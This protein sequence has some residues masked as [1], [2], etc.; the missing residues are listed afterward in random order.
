MMPRA[1]AGAKVLRGKGP[2]GKN[3]YKDVDRASGLLWKPAD[4]HRPAEGREL[5]NEKLAEALKRGQMRFTVEEFEEF[6]IG[7]L[8]KNDVIKAGETYFKPAWASPIVAFDGLEPDDHGYH[9]GISVSASNSSVAYPP[10]TLFR[11]QKIFEPGEWSAPGG[12][13]PRCRML[14]VTATYRFPPD[15]PVCKMCL[16]KATDLSVYN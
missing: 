3:N 8:C 4:A 1:Y 6:G 10:Y 16:Q 7:D 15:L 2:D 13:K 14:L 11:V 9:H 12:I 5:S